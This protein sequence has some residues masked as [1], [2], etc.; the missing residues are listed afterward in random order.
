MPVIDLSPPRQRVYRL[1]VDG[2][3]PNSGLCS[4]SI[5]KQMQREGY[6]ISR[7]RVSVHLR[8]LCRSGYIEPMRENA[9]PALY[10]RGKNAGIL[11]ALLGN[12]NATP[13][14]GGG[15]NVQNCMQ[16]NKNLSAYVPAGEMHLD[17]CYIYPVMREGDRS[18][19]K[20]EGKE[21]AIF[22]TEPIR[23]FNGVERYPG[24]VPLDDMDVRV[25]YWDAPHKPILKVWPKA[26]PLTPG[27]PAKPLRD[28]AEKAQMAVDVLSK[29][30]G[31]R[32]GHP[33]RIGDPHYATNDPAVIGNFPQGA[34]LHEASKCWLDS[35]PPPRAFETTD[36][37]L[38]D[39]VINYHA[40]AE[41]LKASMAAVDAR[42]KDIATYQAGIA[43]RVAFSE[44]RGDKMDGIIAKTQDNIERLTMIIQTIIEAEALKI[45]TKDNID[46]GVMYS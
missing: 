41:G 4:T 33:E 8:E 36:A 34:E 22:N 11:D 23:E 28:H 5:A 13:P 38:M 9:R 27:Q 2:K 20:I 40:I 35:T 45:V 18:K 44:W 31:W 30:G 26:V 42:V 17:D 24:L 15:G 43:Q 6:E 37:Q 10:I 39:G 16:P 25:E 12:S 1:A 3:A 32:F 21:I 19:L 7:Q 46:S 29:Y 14:H